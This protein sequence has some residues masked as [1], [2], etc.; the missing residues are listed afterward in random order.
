MAVRRRSNLSVKNEP[1]AIVC[2][3]LVAA[4]T[5]G[6]ILAI[7]GL[8]EPGLSLTSFVSAV[9]LGFVFSFPFALLGLPTFFLLRWMHAV[10]WWSAGLAGLLLGVLADLV[11]QRFHNFYIGE[12]LRF[13]LQGAAAAFAFWLLWRRSQEPSVGTSNK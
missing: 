10:R 6:L 5:P 8:D 12:I 2:G 3:V 13:G 11:F 7:S 4:A 9:F 1:L